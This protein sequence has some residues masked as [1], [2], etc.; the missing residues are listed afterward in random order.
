[1]WH[2]A[3]DKSVDINWYTKRVTLYGIYKST[4]LAMMQDKSEGYTETLAFLDRR[5]EDS[6]S[7]HDIFGS[8]DDAVKV[9]GAIGSTVQAVLG[10][11]R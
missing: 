4:E 6:K 2:A 7:L 10:M 1:M 8:P 3:G 9:L 5:F 11:R